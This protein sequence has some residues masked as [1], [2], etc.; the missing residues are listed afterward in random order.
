VLREVAETLNLNVSMNEFDEPNWDIY[1][2]DG[3][4]VP[5]FLFKMQAF[6]RVNHFPGMHVLARKNLLA[7]N[8]QAM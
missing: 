6:Q 4:I 1:W 8:L 5:A 2:L 7:R 3:P